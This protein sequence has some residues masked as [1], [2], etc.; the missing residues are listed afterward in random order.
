MYHRNTRRKDQRGSTEWSVRFMQP[1]LIQSVAR[2]RLL[3]P[4][5][6]A[7]TN[8]WIETKK[9][10]L[11]PIFWKLE[12]SSWNEDEVQSEVAHLQRTKTTTELYINPHRKKA[13]PVIPS[14]LSS[15][16][17]PLHSPGTTYALKPALTRQQKSATCIRRS[18]EIAK[19]N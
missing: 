7:G 10:E 1:R 5:E 18:Q 12:F 16:H 4:R 19:C 13:S 11:T 9:T 15:D 8:F 14:T 2:L 17:S 3:E 6:G